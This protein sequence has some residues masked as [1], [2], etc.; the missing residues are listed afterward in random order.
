[1]LAQQGICPPQDEVIDDAAELSAPLRSQLGSLISGIG[2][3]A[4]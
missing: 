2:L 3:P 1:M 4:G